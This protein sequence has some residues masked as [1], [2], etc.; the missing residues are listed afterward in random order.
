M[1]IDAT[2]VATFLTPHGKGVRFAVRPDTSDWNTCN[3]ITA[4]GDEYSLPTGLTGWALDVGAHIGACTVALLVENPD[5]RVV[6]IEPLP[7]NVALIRENLRLNGVADRALVIE[8]AVSD[9][10]DPVRIGYGEIGD[11][12]R[13]HEF[14][15]NT[16]APDGSRE[17]LADGIP[18]GQLFATGIERFAWTKIDC[19]GGEATFFDSPFVDRLDHIEG[20]VH[21]LCGGR[22]LRELLEATHELDIPR[23]ETEPDFGP[24]TA[25]LKGST[26]AFRGDPYEGKA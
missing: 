14:I 26:A 6:A 11:P 22:R 18:L 5:L 15:G 25:R 19:E 2:Q 4:V 7:E 9:T 8:G 1:A 3:A 21:P 23:W 24:F 17:V 20:E 10:Q 13:I 16:Q 12:T